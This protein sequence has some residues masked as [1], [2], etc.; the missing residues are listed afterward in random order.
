MTLLTHVHGYVGQC[1]YHLL[2][3][4][5]LNETNWQHYGSTI[6]SSTVPDCIDLQ[7]FLLNR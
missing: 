6:Q 7:L 1:S 4:G 2:A 3:S 5:R